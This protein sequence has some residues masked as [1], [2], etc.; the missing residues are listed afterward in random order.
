MV[1]AQ[2]RLVQQRRGP[3][4]GGVG[5]R[6]TQAHAQC[7]HMGGEQFRLHHRIDRVVAGQDHEAEGEDA[8]G[9][10]PTGLLANCA[11]TIFGPITE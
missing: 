11:C 10:Q 1:A 9:L 4:E 5:Q 7:A 2:A 8:N 3:A 6:I